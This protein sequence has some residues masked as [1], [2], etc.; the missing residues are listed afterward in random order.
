MYYS[1]EDSL[2][3]RSAPNTPINSP[4]TYYINR[5]DRL[6]KE[7]QW[8]CADSPDIQYSTSISD[9]NGRPELVI[10]DEDSEK[11]AFAI[12]IAAVIAFIIP[13]VGFLYL[14][15]FRM[16]CCMDGINTRQ[17]RKAYRVLFAFTI[18]NLI[19]TTILVTLYK[20]D[21]LKL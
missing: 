4:K 9:N 1:M 15:C 16:T 14:C 21:R 2:E 17:K 19:I 8:Y 20:L 10:F 6:T 11:D 13:L 18:T 12:Y 7:R 5:M 3:S